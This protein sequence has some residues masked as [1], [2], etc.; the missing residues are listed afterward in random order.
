MQFIS[1]IFIYNNISLLCYLLYS[2]VSLD[3]Q[4][5]IDTRI[6]IKILGMYVYTTK[7]F[8]YCR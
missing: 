4:Q 7:K 8:E 2:G 1:Y 3:K 6:F 5:R